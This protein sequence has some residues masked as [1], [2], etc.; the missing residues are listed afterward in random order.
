MTQDNPSAH[1]VRHF[2]QILLWPLQL[3]P[4]AAGDERRHWQLLEETRGE[5]AWYR[6]QD[7][8]TADAREFQERHYK[9]FVAFL[10]YV[11]R[12]A[13]GES[14]GVANRLS[15]DP[16]GDSALRVYRRH[17]VAALR[18]TLHEGAQPIVLSVAHVDL[19]FFDDVDVVLLN[20]E[21]FAA[22]LPLTTVRDLL[23]RFGR[24]YPTAWDEGGQGVH[25][26]YRTEW[27]ATDGTVLAVSD[28]G[29]RAK[30]LSFACQHR[31]PCVSSHWTF[32]LQP[33][34]LDPSE[35]EGALRY[36]QIEYHR[37]PLMAYL[38][39]DDPRGISREEWLRL[40]LVATLHPKEAL[41]R[42]A[43][44]VTEFESRYCYD[45]YWTDTDAGPNTRFICTGRAFV[46]VGDAQAGYFRDAERG[47][48]SQFRHQYT[49][50]FLIA[51]FHRAALLVFSDRLVDAV[52]DLDIRRPESVHRFRQRIHD[53]FEAFLR[54]THRYWFH[55]VSERA[56]IQALYRLLADRL[57]AQHIYDE[58][59][60]ELRDMSQY[61]DSDAQRRQSTTVVRLTVV[62][63][64]SLVGTVAT[65]FMGMNVIAEADAPMLTRWTYFLLALIA[66]GVLTVFT[67]VKS[68]E[69]S[70]L[71]DTLSDD[72]LSF[73]QR[74]GSL[75]RTW[76]RKER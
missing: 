47:I 44:E 58:V 11:Q 71:M 12:F 3:M 9:E 2:R 43:P 40:G 8:F 17:D 56:H 14:R 36:R 45:R 7:E 35:E 21:V 5:G 26:A 16:P 13:Y 57:G 55:E 69:L 70:D 20:V 33:L 68:K 65:G 27:L 72:R 37:M 1:T 64:F 75:G 42:N 52:H 46:V 29:N 62:T 51:H 38:A 63:T 4:L 50:L 30:F 53:S 39:V 41:P 59:K 6:V 66:T 73:R 19:C 24:A 28:S 22:D 76:S 48:L 15:D 31:A 10:P 25:N 74:L 54:F 32:L 34:A 49:L 23:Y 18:L 67:V 60:N 61:L